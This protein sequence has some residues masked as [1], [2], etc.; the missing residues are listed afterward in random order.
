MNMIM[1]MIIIM[2]DYSSDDT[3]YQCI[4]STNETTIDTDNII[5][6]KSYYNNGLDILNNNVNFY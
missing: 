1:N 3:Q 6:N 5:K 2:N 4:N